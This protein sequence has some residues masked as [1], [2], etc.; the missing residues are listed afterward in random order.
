MCSIVVTVRLLLVCVW[1]AWF[2]RNRYSLGMVPRRSLKKNLWKLLLRDCLQAGCSTCHRANNVRV[3]TNS[4]QLNWAVWKQPIRYIARIVLL[5]KWS[6]MCF[7]AQ[8]LVKAW[9][10]AP[11]RQVVWSVLR[12]SCRRRHCC[13][14]FNTGCSRV[15]H[16]LYAPAL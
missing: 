3:L 1:M 6:F 5:V 14:L 9:L 11:I 8:V 13:S 15:C 2:S 12:E 7:H 16:V 4:E 10:H